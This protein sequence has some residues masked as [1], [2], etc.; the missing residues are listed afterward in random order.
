MHIFASI[1]GTILCLVVLL[2]SPA[3]PLSAQE[4]ITGFASWIYIDRSGDLTVTETI[5]VIAAGNRIQR[6]IY[7]DFPTDYTNRA[8]VRVRVGFRV[9]EVMRDGRAEPYHTEQA[10]N[11]TRLYIGDRDVF[12]GPGPHTYSITYQTDRQIGFFADYDELY[13]NVT[14]NDWE[15]PIDKA[16]ATIV[17]PE[18]ASVLQYSIYTGRTGSRASDAEVTEQLDHSI[19]FRT[20]APLAPGEGLTVAVAWPKG[21]V[22]EPDN[23]DR[24]TY[25]L[26]DNLTVLAGAAGLLVL[27]FYYIAVWLKVGKD[28][29]PGVIIPRFEPPEGFTPA[30]GRYVM[31]M[32]FDDKTFTAALVNMAVKKYLVIED[33]GNTF[34]LTKVKKANAGVLTAG[35]K[36][37]ADKLFGGAE[38]LQLKQKN[39]RTIRDALLALEKSLRT[40]FEALHFKRNSQYMIPGL[41]IT[42]LVIASIIFTARQREI[43]GFMS[44]WLSL[45]SM[46]CVA[47]LYGLYNAWKAVLSGGAKI[48]DKGGALFLSLFSLPFLGGWLLGFFVMASAISLVNIVVLLVIL[49]ANIVFYHLLRAPTIHGRKIMDQL[50]GL[51]LYLSVAEKD[52]LN[53]L[54]PPEMTPALFE[55][56]LP[57]ALALNVEQQWSEQFSS[58]L[59]QA[60]KDGSYDPSWYHSSRPFSARSLASSLGSSLSSTIS[61]SSTAPGSSSG[62]RGGGSSGGG[63]GGGGGGGW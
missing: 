10:A 38:R 33:D 1:S 8:G 4:R 28:P 11:G 32:G 55:K 49:T 58:M 40:D 56:F 61:S 41:L 37:I 53:L 23:L 30:A 35:E 51:K 43:A 16:S 17:L 20:T 63:G 7:R 36:K 42:I 45:W 21:I 57:W 18:G 12:L 15:F 25:F 44:I 50:E 9:L 19:S 62:S 27:F 6:G 2:L 34:H 47:L 24:T 29:E 39:H 48:S 13:W 52:R 5:D 60:A 26:K 54:N 3:A 46:G 22:P 14:G 31:R 59:A